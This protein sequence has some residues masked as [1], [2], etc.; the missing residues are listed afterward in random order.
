MLVSAQN[1]TS[2]V[3]RRG[4]APVHYDGSCCRIR[5]NEPSARYSCW[6]NHLHCRRSPDCF[7]VHLMV[8]YGLS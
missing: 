6:Q 1:L 3:A 2:D 7:M 4:A 8:P 5:P